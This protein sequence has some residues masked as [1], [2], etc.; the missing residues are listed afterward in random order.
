MWDT[1]IITPI[2]SLWFS[3]PPQLGVGRGL[4]IFSLLFLE[5][6]SCFFAHRQDAFHPVMGWI[7][8]SPHSLVSAMFWNRKK[9]LGLVCKVYWATL[10]T[11][12][13]VGRTAH[14][15]AEEPSACTMAL[16]SQSFPLNSMETITSLIWALRVICTGLSRCFV[17]WPR[18]GFS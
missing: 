6:R 8:L 1:I 12:W 18:V 14:Y 15:W 10:D 4:L 3:H 16:K 5:R 13:P 7:I 11:A 2:M 17:V 9:F